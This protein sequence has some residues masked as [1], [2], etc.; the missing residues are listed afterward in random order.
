MRVTI[1]RIRRQDREYDKAP[2]AEFQFLSWESIDTIQSVLIKY[3]SASPSPATIYTGVTSFNLEIPPLL[4]LDKP[5][6]NSDLC[7][8]Q[9]AQSTAAMQKQS[10]EAADVSLWA[11]AVASLIDG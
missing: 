10:R 8:A 4:Y 1:L 2:S 6:L 5:S 3:W 7:E 9:W 11:L